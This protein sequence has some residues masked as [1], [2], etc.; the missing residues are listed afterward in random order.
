VACLGQEGETRLGARQ[1]VKSRLRAA[2]CVFQVEA[3][4]STMGY[5]DDMRLSFTSASNEMF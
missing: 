2:F 5:Q 3:V 1:D 4:E